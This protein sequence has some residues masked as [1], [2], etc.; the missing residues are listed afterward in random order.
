MRVPRMQVILKS[1][2]SGEGQERRAETSAS[3]ENTHGRSSERAEEMQ[4]ERECP[5]SFVLLAPFFPHS[6]TALL[7]SHPHPY[8]TLR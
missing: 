4:R 6:H 8:T 2:A 3:R 7:T 1:F 5:K